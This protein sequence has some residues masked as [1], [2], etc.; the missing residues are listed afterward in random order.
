MTMKGAE[1]E[2]VRGSLRTRQSVVTVPWHAGVQRLFRCGAKGGVVPEQEHVRFRVSIAHH[3]DIH[4]GDR[5]SRA[6]YILQM[7]ERNVKCA[8]NT[9]ECQHSRPTVTYVKTP[10]HP[11][12]RGIRQLHVVLHDDERV[13]GRLH[14]EMGPRD[15]DR[16]RTVH[17]LRETL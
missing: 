10:L 7:S 6:G 1:K 8:G 12:E 17:G 5:H 16:L 15:V 3:D 2:D 11:I 14:V 13:E 9:R 4:E